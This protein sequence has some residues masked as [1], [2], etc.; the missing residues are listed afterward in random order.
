MKKPSRFSRYSDP[1]GEF[2][3]SR[4]KFGAWYVSHKILL[5]NILIG[6]LL[7]W[8]VITI[9][10]GLFVWGKYLFFDYSQDEKNIYSIATSYTPIASVHRIFEPQELTISQQK[11]FNSANDR[12]DFAVHVVNPNEDW[13]AMPKYKFTYN[14][15]ETATNEEVLMPGENRF[16][17]L[18]GQKLSFKPSGIK[19][20]LVSVDWKRVDRH[21][22]ADPLQYV[23][24]RYQFET[25]NFEFESA[26]KTDDFD[27]HTISFD[28][29]NNSIFGFWEG[30]F[31][32]VF[33]NKSQVVGIA[34]LVIE[35]F[36]SGD[37]HHVELASFIDRLIVNEVLVE[38]TIDI[39]DEEVYM[40]L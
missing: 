21:E 3:N 4:L 33:K 6:I 16:L 22:V 27:A 38:P 15:G 39:F 24:Q 34:P 35:G 8:N 31:N 9:G 19:L 18:Y 36:D 37:I 11:V 25:S 30:K 23:G 20:E 40:P 28:L 2:S 7:S 14:G 1:T 12:Y 29:A 10:L 32:V 17:I 13:V 26:Q 5:R